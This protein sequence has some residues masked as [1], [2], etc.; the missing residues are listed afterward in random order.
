MHSHKLDHI[1]A[2]LQLEELSVAEN[3]SVVLVLFAVQQVD[4]LPFTVDD[5]VLC[6]AGVLH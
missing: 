3:E 1:S 6:A 5:E 2:R 4:V